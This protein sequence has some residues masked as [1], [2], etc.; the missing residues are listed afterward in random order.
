MWA[1]NAEDA[2]SEVLRAVPLAAMVLVFIVGLALPRAYRDSAPLFACAYAG[3]RLLHLALYADASRR[4]HASWRVIAGFA[5]T[6][7]LGVGLLV[8]VRSDMVCPE[9]PIWRRPV[10][11]W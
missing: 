2:D 3:V 10:Y 1:A 6:V 5:T 8:I 7:G 11:E 4:G 9:L